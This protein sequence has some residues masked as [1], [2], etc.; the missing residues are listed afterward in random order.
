MLNVD[1]S[2]FFAPTIPA[3]PLVTEGSNRKNVPSAMTT[4]TQLH[5]LSMKSLPPFL[6]G[7][8]LLLNGCVAP[9]DPE[10]VLVT[11]NGVPIREKHV[12]E[13]AD[14]RINEEAARVANMGLAYDESERNTTRAVLRDD[15]LHILIER[16]LIDDQL[17][18]DHIEITDADVDAAFL[19]RATDRGQTLEEA[20]EEIRSQGK[21]LPD[22]RARLRWH[23]LGVQKLYDHHAVKKRELTDA[24]ALKI[25]T[26][27]M[28]EF[29]QE[30]ERRVSRI[31]INA[32]P[33][34]PAAPRE[35]ARTRA[36]EL[37]A[38]IKAGEDFAE[39]AKVHSE[40]LAS[41]ARGG[42]RGWSPRG[43]VT[44]PGSDPFGDAAFALKNIGD[45]SEVVETVDGCEIIKLTG[46]KEARQRSFDEVKGFII[47]RERHWEIG[48]FWEQF[49]EQMRQNAKIE[50]NPRELDRRAKK[51]KRDREYNAKIEKQIAREKARE[52][53]L[54]RQQAEKEGRPVEGTEA[55]A[56]ATESPPDVP[57]AD[58]AK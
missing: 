47:A 33:D 11:V 44:E 28:P 31:L 19:A 58:G 35:T 41:R 9:V 2:R 32:P 57:P 15:V 6:I 21:I 56:T 3:S 1:Y 10:Q 12:I 14:K 49:A 25:Y 46:I 52:E 24:D 5:L 23:T 13:E 4:I 37:L 27:S 39:L 16:Q 18:A 50:W 20:M 17:K 43:F 8:S 55:T 38:R 42:D 29:Y 26:E 40:D 34:L 48:N 54:A 53:K 30:E 51:E 22:V 36:D 45:V 7:L